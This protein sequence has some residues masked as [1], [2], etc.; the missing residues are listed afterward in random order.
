[1]LLVLLQ[2]GLNLPPQLRIGNEL[3]L[4]QGGAA[5]AAAEWSGA[6]ANISGV[7]GR[8]T[9]CG[10]QAAAT[11]PQP[12]P[13]ACP[14]ALRRVVACLKGSV[15][16]DMRC[17]SMVLRSTHTRLSGSSTGSCMRVRAQQVDSSA[18]ACQSVAGQCR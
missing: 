17:R 4:G 14:P 6:G 11:V 13:T 12:P 18:A 15:A 7:G 5:A 10:A 16:L 1:M 8:H 3:L 2:P 9:P